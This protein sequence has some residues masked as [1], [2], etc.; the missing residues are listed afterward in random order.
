VA[1]VHYTHVLLRHSSP[2]LHRTIFLGTLVTA[3][4]GLIAR[5]TKAVPLCSRWTPVCEAQGPL[6]ATSSPKCFEYHN[7]FRSLSYQ[8]WTF[9][10]PDPVVRLLGQ[11]ATGRFAPSQ[12]SAVQLCRPQSSI[13]TLKRPYGA[14][15]TS[16]KT[17]RLMK[18]LNR[19]DDRAA[20]EGVHARPLLTCKLQTA[21]FSWMCFVSG[22]RQEREAGAAAVM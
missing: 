10:R 8:L 1:W 13:C 17:P 14:A 16:I 19:Q 9:S 15:L 5:D 6:Q 12:N 2:Q 3:S 20:T 21:F 11:G 4:P 18:S 7:A 22:R